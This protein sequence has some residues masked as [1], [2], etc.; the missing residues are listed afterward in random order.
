MIDNL[1][2]LYTIDNCNFMTFLTCNNE[3]WQGW[4]FGILSCSTGRHIQHLHLQPPDVQIWCV[5]L[6]S[7]NDLGISWLPFCTTLQ[8]TINGKPHQTGKKNIIIYQTCRHTWG[9]VIVSKKGFVCSIISSYFIH[10]AKLPNIH[11]LLFSHKV[12][13]DDARA[14]C[15]TGRSGRS[16]FGAGAVHPSPSVVVVP[17][18]VL[19]TETSQHGLRAEA[20]CQY[21]QVLVPCHGHVTS[22]G[23]CHGLKCMEEENHLPN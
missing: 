7:E 8:E 21:G 5:N 1:L 13:P 14:A 2:H 15:G 16:I 22:W 4:S 17:S 9:Y 11:W 12:L 6:R 3:H 23:T 10:N 18:P 19:A 20:R